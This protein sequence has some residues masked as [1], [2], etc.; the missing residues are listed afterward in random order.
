MSGQEGWCI[1]DRCI[2]DASPPPHHYIL[3]TSTFTSTLFADL[4]RWGGEF[5]VLFSTEYSTIICAQHVEQF[6]TYIHCNHLQKDQN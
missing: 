2:E 6:K 4:V 5:N 1:G 3:S